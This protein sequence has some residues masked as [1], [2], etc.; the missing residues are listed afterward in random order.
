MNNVS[1]DPLIGGA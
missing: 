1:D